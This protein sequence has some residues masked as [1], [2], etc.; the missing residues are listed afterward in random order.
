M[1]GEIRNPLTIP[2]SKLIDRLKDV[3]K[4]HSD[5]REKAEQD[6]ADRRK[7][8]LDLVDELDT[9]QVANILSNYVNGSHD[10]LKEW[11][12]DVHE[13]DVYHTI[14]AEP[15][16][17]ETALDRTIRVLELANN[18]EIEIAP[19]DPIYTYL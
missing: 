9:D 7:E 13:R 12:K 3:R 5:K 8:L 15:T 19:T 16:S 6:A 14:P 4:E 1:A 2:R 17:V 18:Q 10:G 11:L